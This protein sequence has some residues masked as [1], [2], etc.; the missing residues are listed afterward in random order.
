MYVSKLMFGVLD[1]NIVSHILQPIG[2]IFIY[3]YSVIAHGT[4][5][6]YNGKRVSVIFI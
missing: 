4:H 1:G 2:S 5:I 3:L 6:T